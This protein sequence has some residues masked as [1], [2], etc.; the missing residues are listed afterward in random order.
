MLAHGTL[1]SHPTLPSPPRRKG[2]DSRNRRLP[3]ISYQPVSV[4]Y[5]LA[6]SRE[7]E[8]HGP[9]L[10][11][12]NA[13]PRAAQPLCRNSG[14]V[15]GRSAP[16]RSYPEI[17]S[18]RPLTANGRV[19][20]D[21]INGPVEIT[22]WNRNEVQID[23]VKTARDQQRLDEARIEV[24]A[25]SNSVEIKTQYP[26]GHNNNNTRLGALHLARPGECTPGPHRPGERRSGGAEGDRRR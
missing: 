20:L 7:R 18:P 10:V 1:V 26:K 19:S 12:I 15:G 24:N 23:A 21:N 4:N 6:P 14:G 5:C 22:G 11:S 8:V 17:P 2:T 3:Q 13:P 9:L 16:R 25:G